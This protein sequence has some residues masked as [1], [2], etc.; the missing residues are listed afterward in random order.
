M[1]HESELTMKSLM[2][3]TEQ[4]L[5]KMEAH[6]E[7]EEVVKL[8]GKYSCGCECQKALEKGALIMHC[9]SCKSC[10]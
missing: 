7:I 10:L 8:Y 2:T 1:K 9:M 3:E 5:N 4:K 6:K